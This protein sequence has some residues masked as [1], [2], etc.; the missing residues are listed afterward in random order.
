MKKILSLIT[1]FIVLIMVTSCTKDFLERQPLDQYGEPA[2][3]N[4]L[5]LMETFVNNIYYEGIYHGH[6]GKIG[7]QT[8]CDEAMRV[9]DRGAR[10]VCRSV[11]SPSFKPIFRNQ[12]QRKLR[13]D[14]LYS[15]VRA[16]N[17]FLSQVEKHTYN[18]E[19]LKNRLTGEVHFLRG[20]LYH[21]LTIQYGGVPI[22]DRPYAL[23][24]DH[25]AVRNTYEESVQFVAAEF[26]R[27]AALLPMEHTGANTGRATKGAALAMKARALLYAAS[28]LY[29]VSDW[30]NGYAHPELVG[31]TGGSRTARWQAAKDAAKA[32][33]DLNIYSLHK[34]DP[35]PGDD[36]SKNY[37]EIFLLQHTSEDIFVRQFT[38]TY[39]DRW[40]GGYR[41][42][43]HFMPGGYHC[44]GSNNPTQNAVD[45]YQMNDGSR[46]DWNNT[47]H[48]EDP[49]L[50]REPRFYANILYDGVV[51]APRPSDV[52]PLDPVGIIQTGFY[53]NPDGT[54]RGGLD[55][56]MSPIEDWNNTGSG[57]Y[58]RK[59]IDNSYVFMYEDQDNPWRHMRYA[60][61]LLSYAE[62]CNELGEDDEA[63]T[64]INM[65]RKRAG[66]PEI[67]SVGD[68]LR[69]DIR[70]ERRIE[71]MFEDQRYWDIRRWMT[72]PEVIGAGARGIDIRY[73]HGQEKPVYTPMEIIEYYWNDRSYFMPI[74]LDE[75]NRNERLIQNPLY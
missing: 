13:W 24:D 11:V 15:N 74:S 28:D 32:V 75:M 25:L 58:Q 4:D 52:V 48:K 65:I 71:L 43:L 10:D 57:Y 61:I 63:R 49:Y 8:L 12:S 64:Y 36:I 45:D 5:D 3:W 37:E 16:T 68:Q 6:D 39:R 60:E 59:H 31:Y 55:T 51:W 33:M 17:L 26:D 44:H 22:I 1:I 14:Y 73:Y 72:A 7:M 35:S 30:T 53:E 23:D 38:A 21:I 19:A 18:D 66:M 62:A 29:N 20:Y 34:G 41:P 54:W 27:A 2:V 70:H 40:G 47:A 50:N 69:E 67:S 42:G 56:R 46:F 9:A